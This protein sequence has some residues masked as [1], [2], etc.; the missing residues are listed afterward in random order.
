MFEQEKDFYYTNRESLRKNYLGKSLIIVGNEII[1]VFDDWDT[2]VIE[3]EKK[4]PIGTFCV[5][6]VPVDPKSEIWEIF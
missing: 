5:K 2:A 3:T 6:E 4:M 1:G